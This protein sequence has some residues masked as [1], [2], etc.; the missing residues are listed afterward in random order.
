M[1][2]VVLTYGTFDMFHVGHLALLERLKELGDYLIVGVSTDE[3]NEIKGK[4]TIISHTDRLNIIKGLKC[5]D[6]AIPEHNWKQK[7]NDIKQYNVSIFG[8]GDDW[9]GSFDELKE[10]CEVIYLPRTEGVS[11][12]QLKHT[13]KVLDRA[14]IEEIKNSLDKI[15][16]IVDKFS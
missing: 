13:L 12:T 4:K 2:K 7:I 11:S 6:I 16:S 1:K 15:S 5:V 14:H 9:K 3:F 10:Y 8:M